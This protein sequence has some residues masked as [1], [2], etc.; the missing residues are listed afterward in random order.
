[1]R[2]LGG[3]LNRANL[4]LLVPIFTGCSSSSLT[5]GEAQSTFEAVNCVTDDV[6]LLARDAVEQGASAELAVGDTDGGFSIHG[7]A[8][9]GA[10]WSGLVTIDGDVSDDGDQVAYD[11]QVALDQVEVVD[12]PTL[13]GV[14]DLVFTVDDFGS[15][16]G[17]W[18]IEASLDG[19]LD[20]TGGATGHAS[21]HYDLGLE[22]DGWS[23]T[24]SATGT[25]N[26]FDVSAWQY[27]AP[28]LTF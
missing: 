18:S 10:D 20:L 4:L 28:I 27:T 2:A 21:L 23:V 17:A 15:A 9:E 19:E 14:V 25:I 11:L 7:S 26:G 5:E 6:V 22:I 16:R 13:D 24:F 12:G 1:M 3:H 8:S